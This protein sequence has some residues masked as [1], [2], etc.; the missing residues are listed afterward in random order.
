M[1]YS[2]MVIVTAWAKVPVGME[3]NPPPGK[4]TVAASDVEITW[5]TVA[6]GVPTSEGVLVKLEVGVLVG[7][8]VKVGV[9][10][11]HVLVSVLV[12]VTVGV[13]VVDKVG[14]FVF[15]LVV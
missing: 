8:K 9:P 3:I 5:E 14:V 1:A 13:F 7:V 11:V 15:P 12:G 4:V 10:G 6:T 2:V